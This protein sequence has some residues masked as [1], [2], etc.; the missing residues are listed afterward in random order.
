VS[1]EDEEPMTPVEQACADAEDAV[2][3][4]FVAYVSAVLDD[5]MEKYQGEPYRE[6]CAS[7]RDG[8]VLIVD[9]AFTIMITQ[10]GTADVDD[11]ARL[12]RLMM[13]QAV[14]RSIEELPDLI[15]TVEA[16]MK[17]EEPSS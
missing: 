9:Q 6:L 15:E 11:M 2:A 17:K 4:G 14:D 1:H 7:I 3:D 10:I 5:R 13:Q 16:M 8:F 12:V